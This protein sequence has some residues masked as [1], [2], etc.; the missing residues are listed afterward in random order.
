MW[1]TNH[2][3]VYTCAGTGG[4]ISGFGGN[5]IF[6]DDPVRGVEFAR[7]PGLKDK[8]YEWYQSDVLS[9]R[10][11]EDSVIFVIQTRWS[12]DDLAGRLLEAQD[13]GGEQWHV[14]HYSALDEEDESYWPE[15]WSTKFY[16]QT[17][18]STMPKTWSSLYMGSPAPETGLYFERTDIHIEEPPPVET[19]RLYGAS[20]RAGTSDGGDFTVHMV[21]GVDQQDRIWVL[22]VYRK[23][24]NTEVAHLN[25]IVM[26]KRWKPTLWVEEKGMIAKYTGPLLDRM[27]RESKV[28]INRR[29]IDS[30]QDKVTKSLAIQGY[31]RLHG[32]YMPPAAWNAALVDELVK[33]TGAATGRDDQVDTLGLIGNIVNELAPARIEEK[34]KKMPYKSSAEYTVRDWFGDD[35]DLNDGGVGSSGLLQANF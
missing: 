26:M 4:G 34:E 17:R 16:H 31:M 24:V 6:I 11:S 7:S 21:C 12:E 13:K 20:D 8:M 3:G 35:P 15:K 10:E 33:F 9:R 14:I 1:A 30:S 19:M 18:S 29:F 27:M 28:W 32:L 5:Y 22:D 2:G 25:N 23:Q